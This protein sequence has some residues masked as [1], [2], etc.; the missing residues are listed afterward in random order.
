M[1]TKRQPLSR[2]P[3]RPIT[4]EMIELFVRLILAA[5]DDEHWEDDRKP[6]RRREYL[7]I[8]KRLGWVLLDR[9]GEVSGLDPEL[10]GPM[11]AYME[12][13]ASGHG[14]EAGQRLRQALLEAVRARRKE[15]ER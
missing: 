6:G 7:N 15:A 13:L 11:P 3:H 5:H 1:I 4:D 12:K 2:A 14:W 8:I 10:D 9:L